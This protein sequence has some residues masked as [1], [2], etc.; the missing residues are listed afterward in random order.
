VAER[1][2]FEPSKGFWP[3]RRLLGI[4][5]LLIH[6]RLQSPAFPLISLSL[7]VELAVDASLSVRSLLPYRHRPFLNYTQLRARLRVRVRLSLVNC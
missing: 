3:P 2:G 1:E 7:A 5:N 4:S 6:K